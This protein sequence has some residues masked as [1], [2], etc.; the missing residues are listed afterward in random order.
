M[1]ANHHSASKASPQG[2][3]GPQAF[4]WRRLWP[5]I[6]IAILAVLFFG[7]GF[8]RYL[9]IDH[10]RQHHQRLTEFVSENYVLAAATFIALYVVTVVLSL[11]AA[12]L[13]TITGGF[14]FGW[15]VGGLLS[16]FG[17]TVGASLLFLAAKTSVGDYLR[18]CAGP[19]MRRAEV[20]FSKNRWSYLL[21]LRLV[22]AVPFFVANLLPAF[23]G[24]PFGCYV[25]T[26]FFGIMPGG[27]VYSLIGT[28]LGETLS[29]AQPLSLEGL[30]TTEMR[31]GLLALAVL[32][33]LPI[34]VKLFL[35]KRGHQG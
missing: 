33:G 12:S 22:P 25:L 34:A 23:L 21:M 10:L 30:L 17:A 35:A 26:T 20:G 27:F 9:E 18:A 15:F 31:L 11:P 19:W 7:L 1:T 3:P 6:A 14:L 32:S 13:L 24:V 28:G 2:D 29:S 4:Q 5:L 16:V 8:D